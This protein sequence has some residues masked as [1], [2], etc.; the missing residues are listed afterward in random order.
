MT[1]V[2]ISPV[3]DKKLLVFLKKIK[4]NT[5]KTETICFFDISKNKLHMK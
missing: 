2:T 1:L 3:K 5:R 4:M